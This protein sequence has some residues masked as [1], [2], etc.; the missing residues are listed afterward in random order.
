LARLAVVE[1]KAGP[2]TVDR[3]L[4]D[5]IAD[6]KRCGG[7]ALDR[8]EMT[9]DAFIRPT[10]GAHEVDGLAAAMVRGWHAAVAEAPARLP[11][12]KTAKPR[13][14]REIDLKES[15]AVRQ[16]RQRQPNPGPARGRRTSP[17]REG[18]A[19]TDEACRRVQPFREASAPEIRYLDHTEAQRLVNSCEPTFRRLV[20]S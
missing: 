20:R 13:N 1:E 7:K 6:H 8:F 19:K 16:P 5:Y 15:K 17:S 10:L 12:R 14:V 18:H 9:A 11:T 3:C 4:D 2:H